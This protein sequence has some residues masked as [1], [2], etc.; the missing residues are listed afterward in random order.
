MLAEFVPGVGTDVSLAE[1][2]AQRADRDLAFPWHNGSI[3]DLTRSSNELDVA[4]LLAGF[5]KPG[6]LKAALDLAEWVRPKPPQP[7]PR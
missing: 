6:G 2:T 3:D 4:A 1:N 5:D 7:Q